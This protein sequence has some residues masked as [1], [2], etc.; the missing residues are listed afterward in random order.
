MMRQTSLSAYQCI[1]EGLGSRQEA[2][3]SII[4]RRGAVD[5]KTICGDLGLPINSVSGRISE[6]Q[7]KGL[8]KEDH[9]APCRKTGHIVTYWTNV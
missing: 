1:R 4:R 7:E 8:V 9:R 6:L 3:L 2:V 5:T